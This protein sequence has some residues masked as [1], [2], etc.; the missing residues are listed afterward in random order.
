MNHLAEKGVI[1]A[2]KKDPDGDIVWTVTGAGVD[3]AKRIEFWYYGK[4]P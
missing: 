1:I 3:D 2:G 4:S